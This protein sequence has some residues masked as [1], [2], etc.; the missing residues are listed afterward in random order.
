MGME[1]GSKEMVVA[2]EEALK[3]FISSCDAALQ[4]FITG[5]TCTGFVLF[6]S[7]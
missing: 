2:S 7:V 5:T 6:S 3:L 4:L 1:R